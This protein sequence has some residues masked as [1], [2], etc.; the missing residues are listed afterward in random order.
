MFTN[1]T[2]FIKSVLLR[3]ARAPVFAKAVAEV[4][5]EYCNP[6]LG[7]T[8][9][10]RLAVAIACIGALITFSPR[11]FFAAGFQSTPPPYKAEIIW[12][13]YHVPHIFANV[14]D[15]GTDADA[16]RALG[17]QQMMDFPV[18]TLVNLWIASG[19][20]ALVFGIV[21]IGT[22]PKLPRVDEISQRMGHR[23]LATAQWNEIVSL[24][25]S[26]T[27]PFD[28][29]RAAIVEYTKGV[30]AGRAFWYSKYSPTNP[31][32]A[33][34]KLK[35]SHKGIN[36]Q[37]LIR[38]MSDAPACTVNEWNVLAFTYVLQDAF[39]AQTSSNVWMTSLANGAGVIMTS[40][41]H[42]P[43]SDL[44][45]QTKLAGFDVFLTHNPYSIPPLDSC[46]RKYF[47]QID[48]KEF[49]V[50]GW[51]IPGLPTIW[52]GY[53]EFPGGQYTWGGSASNADSMVTATWEGTAKKEQAVVST[54]PTPP[55]TC[56]LF[57]HVFSLKQNT[58]PNVTL[59]ARTF[60]F[61]YCEL[62]NLSEVCVGTNVY[63]SVP[64]TLG[65]FT[66]DGFSD[67]PV[68]DPLGDES[69]FHCIQKSYRWFKSGS[70][71]SGNMVEFLLRM[72]FAVNDVEID[73]ALNCNGKG[74]ANFMVGSSN[75]VMKYKLL[76]KAAVPGVG[77]P[78]VKV[79]IP[80]SNGGSTLWQGMELPASYPTIFHSPNTRQK[81]W[82]ANNATPNYVAAP[83]S[84]SVSGELGAS[85]P[86][87]VWSTATQ[88]RPWR[89]VR[90]DNLLRPASAISVTQGFSRFVATDK[91]DVAYANLHPYFDNIF[92]EKESQGFAEFNSLGLLAML[93][94]IILSA[95][96]TTPSFETSVKSDAAVVFELLRG[97]YMA[98]VRKL[99]NLPGSTSTYSDFIGFNVIKTLDNQA[100]L[101]MSEDEKKAIGHAWINLGKYFSSGGIIL[102]N[103]EAFSKYSVPEPPI[104]SP[105]IDLPETPNVMRL[106]R[107]F[108]LTGINYA[109]DW[110]P[111]PLNLQK[112]LRWNQ[113][114]MIILT[115]GFAAPP[116]GSVAMPSL[117]FPIDGAENDAFGSAGLPTG[118]PNSLPPL[119]GSVIV[120]P[121]GGCSES[122]FSSYNQSIFTYSLQ[123]SSNLLL[124]PDTAPDPPTSADN[125]LLQSHRWGSHTLLN[126]VLTPGGAPVAQYLSVL[127]ETELWGPIQVGPFALIQQSDR[128]NLPLESANRINAASDP[129][130]PNDWI[131]FITD[132]ASIP[133]TVFIEIR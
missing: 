27:A 67:Y 80:L 129:T 53:S 17:Y 99:V 103:A 89:Q 37:I 123:S 78:N 70:N 90:A 18:T 48:G 65:A 82:I 119:P 58:P 8:L 88:V 75:G 45:F 59:I 49:K 40:D 110:Y 56:P 93:R 44:K 6:R 76:A 16:F 111:Q 130:G 32:P 51:T 71:S 116:T 21:K 5:G 30:N 46:Y 117:S 34:S 92:T 81:T 68:I 69:I 47:V 114:N 77:A 87:H 43:D 128:Y 118:I 74:H 132:K 35:E 38:M 12:D 60:P 107:P 72:S 127:P 2:I 57:Y 79:N 3:C 115:P 95:G 98:E 22:E 36:E 106:Q 131:P 23:A 73:S 13:Q 112:R 101:A 133:K 24:S 102:K 20:T 14:L 84:G 61:K 54:I 83:T 15:G 4:Q 52:V 1:D 108:T 113:M 25:G 9:T 122:L 41:P 19:E 50:R 10:R 63:Y 29:I 86:N 94:N 33:W 124:V 120:I 125:Y 85:V 96:S 42:Q 109:A 26:G 62:T 7:L 100:A 121:I 104:T 105:G 97:L 91:Q 11:S 39:G 31:A 64:G 66:S 126:V 55:T 28:R